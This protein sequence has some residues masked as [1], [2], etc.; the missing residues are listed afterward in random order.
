M[1]IS[2]V[3]PNKQIF[4]RSFRTKPHTLIGYVEEVGQPLK[5]WVPKRSATK[6]TSALA[7][8]IVRCRGTDFYDHRWP[9]HLDNTVAGGITARA[10]A[11]ETVVRECAEEASLPEDFVEEHVRSTGVISYTFR[12][13]E[14]WVQPEVQY[15]YDLKFPSSATGDEVIVPKTNVDDGEVESFSL[16]TVEEVVQKMCEGEFKPN[17]SLVR[18]FVFALSRSSAFLLTSI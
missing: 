12:T 3:C 14:G 16:L 15:V 2:L 5:I 7:L 4:F 18:S 6:Q 13:K 8:L 11:Y 1:F 17:C 9:S 10:S